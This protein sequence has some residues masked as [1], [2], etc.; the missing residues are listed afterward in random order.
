[1]SSYL[2]L[3]IVP[4]DRL[5]PSAVTSGDHSVLTKGDLAVLY[6]EREARPSADREELLAFADAVTR[7][8]AAVPALP[9]RFGTGLDNLA[10][11]E[12][13]LGQRQ[14]EWLERLSVVAGHVEVLVTVQDDS[15]PSPT[16]PVRGEPG[17]GREYLLSRAAARRHTETLLEDLE[18]CLEPHCTEL[19]RLRE[20]GEIQ[21]ACLVPSDG[22]EKLRAAID[23]WAGPREGLRVR[24]TGPWPPFSFTEKE[25]R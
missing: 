9:V 6:V 12:D 5:P 20:S 23:G 7:I 8:S 16:Q 19:R 11:L 18:A 14:E 17:A 4:A 13:L 2:L 3:A 24:T 15:T 21:V 10:E 1:M 22:V 25:P